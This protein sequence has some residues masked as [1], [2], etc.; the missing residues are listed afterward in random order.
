MLAN[1]EG[2]EKQWDAVIDVAQTLSPIR[3]TLGHIIAVSNITRDV[4]EQKRAERREREA[5]FLAFSRPLPDYSAW[6]DC[7]LQL[8]LEC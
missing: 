8:N 5:F 2:P 7:P 1:T 6:V 4:S 3:D